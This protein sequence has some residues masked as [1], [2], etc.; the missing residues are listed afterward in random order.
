M[1]VLVM[2]LLSLLLMVIK[3]SLYLHYQ[4]NNICYGKY[5]SKTAE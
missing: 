2:I 3:L 5:Y 1:F 4:M